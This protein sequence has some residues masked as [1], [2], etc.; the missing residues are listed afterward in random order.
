[1]MMMVIMIII[2]D[3]FDVNVTMK[4]TTMMMMMMRMTCQTYFV[5]SI[6]PSINQS[7]QPSIHPSI[8]P[9]INQS[10]NPTVNPSIHLITTTCKTFT[11]ANTRKQTT[12]MSYLEFMQSICSQRATARTGSG[13]GFHGFK[14][15]LWGR[16]TSE[17]WV[18]EDLQRCV[19]EHARLRSI[20]SP[21]N[22]FG[23]SSCGKVRISVDC[24]FGLHP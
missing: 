7:I 17:G 3:Y 12:L 24:G 21:D 16:I 1:M 4:T 22:C 11:S 18:A 8:H 9:S 20:N 15:H 13:R 2:M 5:Y 23:L 19:L 10:I 6:H 14:G